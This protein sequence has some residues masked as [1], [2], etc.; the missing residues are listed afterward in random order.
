MLL[1]PYAPIIP[2]GRG[3]CGRVSKA[4][5]RKGRRVGERRKVAEDFRN[6]IPGEDESELAA[7]ANDRLHLQYPALSPSSLHNSSRQTL[8]CDRV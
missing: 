5:E 1:R 6:G 2:L 4:G 3:P 8:R 7:K